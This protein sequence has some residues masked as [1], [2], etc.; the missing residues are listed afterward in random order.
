MKPLNYVFTQFQFVELKYSRVFYLVRR[1]ERVNR[2]FS[3]FWAILSIISPICA[4]AIICVIEAGMV[5][6]CMIGNVFSKI[7]LIIDKGWHKLH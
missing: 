5:I 2:R 6:G 3:T 4:V 1:R 7:Y